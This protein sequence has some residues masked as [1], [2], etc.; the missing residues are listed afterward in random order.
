MTTLGWTCHTRAAPSSDMF[1]L[2]SS[3]FH[4]ALTTVRHLLNVNSFTMV[5]TCYFI[6]LYTVQWHRNEST[7]CLS[8]VHSDFIFRFTITSIFS[9]EPGL[10]N[11]LQISS[12]ST[13]ELFWGGSVEWDCMNWMSSLL[14]KQQ[15]QGTDENSGAL[16]T[17]DT[18]LSNLHSSP[19]PWYWWKPFSKATCTQ[20][21][22]LSDKKVQVK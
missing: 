15:H 20:H 10:A 19:F 3:Y 11:S 1:N 7:V 14:P 5:P 12:C 22:M 13:K 21:A 9:H 18:I 2:G 17:P 6:I 4:V 8:G 16:T